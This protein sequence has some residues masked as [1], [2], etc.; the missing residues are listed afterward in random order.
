[1]VQQQPHTHLVLGARQRQRLQH[2]A[3]RQR[4]VGKLVRARERSVDQALAQALLLLLLL[5]RLLWR[6]AKPAC[7]GEGE[8][9]QRQAVG[10]KRGQLRCHHARELHP[11][12]LQGVLQ[13]QRTSWR[14]VAAAAAAAAAA[15]CVSAR[16]HQP[17]KRLQCVCCCCCCM[18][19]ARIACTVLHSARQLLLRLL[20]R[21][22]LLPLRS[23]RCL[24]APDRLLHR[25][26]SGCCVGEL[27][28]VQMLQGGAL[29][30][31]QQQQHALQGRCLQLRDAARAG[32]GGEAARQLVRIQV[33]RDV[34]QAR[35]EQGREAA[36]A[37]RHVDAAAT[38]RQLRQPHDGGGQVVVPGCGEG[39]G[40]R[41]VA[42][43]VGGRQ[44]SCS[45]ACLHRHNAPELGVVL[46]HQCLHVRD[47]A[48]AG[49]QR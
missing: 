44:H 36:A 15:A 39:Q 18:W 34:E 14:P 31:Q 33:L 16:A 5:L 46:Q 27:V 12:A 25:G 4:G 40:A 9:R 35:G 20:L 22:L 24:L 49:N 42:G 30:A 23:P 7:G 32:E 6:R 3:D 38:Q 45:C 47:A 21:G 11:Q 2:A 48:C 41:V 26:R 43:C 19:F 13:R 17:V 29:V 10:R 1:M 28:A 8:R 37:L